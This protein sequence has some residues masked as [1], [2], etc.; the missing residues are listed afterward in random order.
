M[1]LLPEP[2]LTA[3]VYGDKLLRRNNLAPE[4]WREYLL[5]CKLPRGYKRRCVNKPMDPFGDY[6]TIVIR[7][8]KSVLFRL[9]TRPLTLLFW[10]EVLGEP[11]PYLRSTRSP[12][13]AISLYNTVIETRTSNTPVHYSNS[14]WI[15]WA[16]FH[17]YFSRLLLVTDSK[18][19]QNLKFSIWFHK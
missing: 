3:R 14:L 15:N 2:R 9:S 17:A 18:L 5:L 11:L 6:I 7:V 16:W 13:G 10:K 19:P 1:N 8:N 4:L 12:T